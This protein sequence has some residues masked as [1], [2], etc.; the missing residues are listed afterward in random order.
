[1]KTTLKTFNAHTVN[2]DEA[3]MNAMEKRWL[4]SHD[5]DGKLV[6]TEVILR[7]ATP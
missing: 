6:T 1:M 4:C 3:N 5:C 7:E 2:N